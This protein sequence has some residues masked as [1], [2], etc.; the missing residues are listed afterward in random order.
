M[1]FCSIIQPAIN[2][3]ERTNGIAVETY[4][5]K[6]KVKNSLQD[7][8]DKEYFGSIAKTAIVKCVNEN[9]ICRFKIEAKNALTTAIKYLEKWFNFEDSV[10][11]FLKP[12]NLKLAIP[13]FNDLDNIIQKCNINNIDED[14]LFEESIKLQNFAEENIIIRENSSSSDKIWV[15]FFQEFPDCSN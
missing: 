9:E 2:V 8:L 5:L 14:K 6:V 4:D 7:R 1:H 3:L 15:K 11:K 10:F 13:C 12:M